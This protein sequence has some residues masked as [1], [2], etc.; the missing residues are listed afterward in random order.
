MASFG[1]GEGSSVTVA[2]CRRDRREIFVRKH[3]DEGMIAPSLLT[4]TAGRHAR[5]CQGLIRWTLET[6]DLKERVDYSLRATIV[7][8]LE[9]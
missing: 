3:S 2:D 9:T 7:W 8:T 1:V 6:E 5:T 4:S